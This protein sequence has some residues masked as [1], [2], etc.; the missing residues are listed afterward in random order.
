MASYLYSKLSSFLQEKSQHSAR[1]N[2]GVANGK[3]AI[4]SSKKSTDEIPV[5]EIT[6]SPS[7][8]P[9]RIK[10][11]ASIGSVSGLSEDSRS[12]DE[13]RPS[14]AGSKAGREIDEAELSLSPTQSL[15][16]E[17]V[18]SPSRKSTE[19]LKKVG[20]IAW[21]FKFGNLAVSIIRKIADLL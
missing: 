7:S 8:L 14:S 10:K 2:G 18:M 13:A 17:S 4:F 20:E 9:R 11:A 12:P 1:L 6:D 5:V 21:R 19:A 15:T 3:S 16:M